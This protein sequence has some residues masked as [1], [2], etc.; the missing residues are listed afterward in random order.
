MGSSPQA[1]GAQPPLRGAA[2]LA[3]LIPASAGSTFAAAQFEA[4]CLAHPR[5][6]GEHRH[7]QAR[8]QRAQG[9]SPQARGA[10]SDAAQPKPAVGLIPAS[11][12][13]TSRLSGL[14]GVVGA[15]PRKRGEHSARACFT[16]AHRGSSPQARGAQG[17]SVRAPVAR[18]LIPASAGG[19]RGPPRTPRGFAAHPRKR[20]EHSARGACRGRR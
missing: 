14:T 19:T 6:R 17:L 1:R 3:G 2:R 15:H 7:P 8:P 12:G 4:V 20:G 18:G 10:R 16:V 11:A 5:K 13:S 9:S